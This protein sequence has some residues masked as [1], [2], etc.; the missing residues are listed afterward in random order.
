MTLEW[1]RTLFRA[2]CRG[3]AVG[4][5]VL[6]DRLLALMRKGTDLE[7]IDRC[8]ENL[9]WGSLPV[10]AYM[11]VG[12]PTETEEEA[13]ASFELLRGYV[14]EGK[15]DRAIYS[16]YGIS[17]RSP[18]QRFPAR[19]GITAVHPRPGADLSPHCF[20]FDHAGMDRRRAA[21]LVAEF[22]AAIDEARRSRVGT[23]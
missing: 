16:L 7:L 23:A 1:A 17:P 4:V 2:G 3:P 19:Y 21:G 13:R 14:L 8:L 5:E 15:I 18:V 22:S 9:A 20:D 11:I 10:M 6:D 12:L